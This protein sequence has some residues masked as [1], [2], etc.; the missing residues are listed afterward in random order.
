MTMEGLD[1]TRGVIL[2]DDDP[3][4]RRALARM[5]RQEGWVTE[6]APGGLAAMAMQ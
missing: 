5:L 1:H 3:S 6:E 2:V 4:A